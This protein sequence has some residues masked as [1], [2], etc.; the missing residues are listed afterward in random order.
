MKYVALLRGINVGGNS[1]VDM[2]QLKGAFERIGFTEVRT[3]INSGNIIF[4]NTKH[5]ES[6]LIQ[7][8]EAEILKEFGFEVKVV[9]RTQKQIEAI[10]KTLP[11]EWVN[12]ELMKC[13]VMFLW[14]E[15]DDESI[16]RNLPM[17]K[18][19]D[20]LKYIPGVVIWRVDRDKVTKSGLLKIIGTKYYKLMTIRNCNTVRKLSS[21]M[22]E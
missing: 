3:Y 10:S 9:I 15:V 13:D 14:D 17:R 2:K 22:N 7:L 12:N 16:L 1:K 4:S 5:S 21:L 8:I 18:E 19:F 6:K 20:D 11:A